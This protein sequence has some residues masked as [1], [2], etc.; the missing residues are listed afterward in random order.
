MLLFLVFNYAITNIKIIIKLFLIPFC[1]YD[2]LIKKDNY[3]FF[4]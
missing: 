1:N 3:L 4:L 2:S